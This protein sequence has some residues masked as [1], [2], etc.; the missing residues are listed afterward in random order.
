MPVTNAHCLVPGGSRI[1][2]RGREN[3]SGGGEARFCLY[4]R[5][6]SDS[7]YFSPLPSPADRSLPA[8]GLAERFSPQIFGNKV[9][10]NDCAR[11]NSLWGNWDSIPIYLGIYRP[12]APVFLGNSEGTWIQGQSNTS[13]PLE[14]MSGSFL[15]RR[16]FLSCAVLSSELPLTGLHLDSST[17][18][19]LSWENWIRELW[20]SLPDKTTVS[21]QLCLWSMGLIHC[22]L[23]VGEGPCYT[24]FRR[25]SVRGVTSS[26]RGGWGLAQ[27]SSSPNHWAYF[28]LSRGMVLNTQSHWKILGILSGSGFLFWFCLNAFR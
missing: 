23:T 8:W 27:V 24:V 3:T 17:L 20:Q 21:K 4:L 6:W 10:Y 7:D 5:M 1:R 22:P 15:E 25:A 11:G 9:R 19:P 13:A 16:A 18:V 26:Y 28:R 14:I 12:S 2:V